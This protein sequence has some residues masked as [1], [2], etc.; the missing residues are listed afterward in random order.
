MITIPL[1]DV[2]SY[3]RRKG[4]DLTCLEGAPIM[5][6]SDMQVLGPFYLREITR[7]NGAPPDFALYLGRDA[8]CPAAMGWACGVLSAARGVVISGLLFDDDFLFGLHCHH[9]DGPLTWHAPRLVRAQPVGDEL[10]SFKAT[11][12]VT[13]AARLRAVL[14]YEM[15]RS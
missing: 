5:V 9:P 6:G 13:P 14:E 3:L 7:C 1:L 12:P 8:V 2:V 4:V 11:I 15:G 10:P